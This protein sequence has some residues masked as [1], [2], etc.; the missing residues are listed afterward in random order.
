MI[1]GSAPFQP[2]NSPRNFIA[3]NSCFNGRIHLGE[4]ISEED[5]CDGGLSLAPHVT[6]EKSREKNDDEEFKE[7]GPPDLFFPLAVL[8]DGVHG[9]N[10][11][12]QLNTSPYGSVKLGLFR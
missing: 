6:D 7:V 4:N 1:G 3:G 8:W 10:Q 9:V 12:V 11:D 5:V 2:Q